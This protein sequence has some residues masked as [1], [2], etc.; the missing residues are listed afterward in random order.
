METFSAPKIV[1]ALPGLW[2]GPPSTHQKIWRLTCSDGE[3]LLGRG[4]DFSDVFEFANS[5]PLAST[6]QISYEMIC[7]S[8][9]GCSHAARAS[10]PI[11]GWVKAGDQKLKGSSDAGT[12]RLSYTQPKSRP[13]P[14][15]VSVSS[16][17]AWCAPAVYKTQSHDY[18]E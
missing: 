18:D 8:D 17:P 6:S 2:E 5:T 1:G 9:A 11:K 13:F 16:N 12:L 14:A 7:P 4:L 10:L 15:C 3:G